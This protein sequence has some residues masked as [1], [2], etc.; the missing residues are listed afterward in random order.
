MSAIEIVSKYAKVPDIL[1][2]RHRKA[3]KVQ[4]YLHQ[5]LKEGNSLHE[6]FRVIRAQTEARFRAL[7]RRRHGWKQ[8][9]KSELR[10]LAEIPL[11]DYANWKQEDPDFFRDDD[12]FKKLKKDTPDALVYL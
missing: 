4:E 8:N 3:L 6:Y 9:N 2:R 5:E 7:A 12:N 10:L 11:Q 1:V